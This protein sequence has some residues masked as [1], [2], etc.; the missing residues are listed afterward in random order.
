L[1]QRLT[2][3]RTALLSQ[4]GLFGRSPRIAAVAAPAGM[5]AERRARLAEICLALPEA[6]AEGERHVGFRVHGRTF[7]YYL[8]DHHG[9]GRVA[10]NC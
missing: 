2:N 5:K 4:S 8:D 9:D 6:T 7:A 1:L 10:L 3:G